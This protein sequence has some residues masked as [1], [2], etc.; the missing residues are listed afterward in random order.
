MRIV[1][2]YCT[3]FLARNFCVILIA[4]VNID[5]LGLLTLIC[6]LITYTYIHMRCMYMGMYCVC[7]DILYISY[8]LL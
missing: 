5:Q 2:L 6:A 4:L 1:I 3:Q 8:D 7:M